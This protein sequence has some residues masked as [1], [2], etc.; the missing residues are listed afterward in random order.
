[1][2][3]ALRPTARWAAR[4]LQQPYPCAAS[5]PSR[6]AVRHGQPHPARVAR[7][8]LHGDDKAMAGPT[9]PPPSASRRVV[10][11]PWLQRPGHPHVGPF[12]AGHSGRPSEYGTAGAPAPPAGTPRAGPCGSTALRRSGAAPPDRRNAV[13]PAPGGG[14]ARAPAYTPQRHCWCIGSTYRIR[15]TS[16]YLIVSA[17][18]SIMDTISSQYSRT[19]RAAQAILPSAVSVGVVWSVTVPL[20]R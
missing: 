14:P 11:R 9:L 19:R 13:V 8:L 12:R 5:G 16:G 20:P 7:R 17:N 15:D 18:H 3:S 6:R 4:I 2:S 1:M 10:P